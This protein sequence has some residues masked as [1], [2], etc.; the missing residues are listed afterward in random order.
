MIWYIN[1][2]GS[3]KLVNMWE[4]KVIDIIM[5]NEEEEKFKSKGEGKFTARFSIFNTHCELWP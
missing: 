4:E 3:E 1:I 2:Q 5:K